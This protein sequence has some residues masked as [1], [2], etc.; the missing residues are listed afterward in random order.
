MPFQTLDQNARNR[1]A[2]AVAQTIEAGRLCV[3]EPP[4]FSFAIVGR[5]AHAAHLIGSRQM[6]GGDL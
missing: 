4:D 6:Q 1:L 5:H 3:P 2:V